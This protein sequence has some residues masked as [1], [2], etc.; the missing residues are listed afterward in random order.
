MMLDEPEATATCI[1]EALK[2][3]AAAVDVEGISAAVGG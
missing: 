2:A 3:A 1:I